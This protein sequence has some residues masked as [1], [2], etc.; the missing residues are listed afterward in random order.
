MM[1]TVIIPTAQVFQTAVLKCY[2]LRNLSKAAISLGILL[3]W[4]FLSD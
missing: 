1:S 4:G 3:F 2:G